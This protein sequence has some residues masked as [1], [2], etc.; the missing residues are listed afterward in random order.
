[1][2]GTDFARNVV[3]SVATKSLRSILNGA[4]SKFSPNEISQAIRKNESLWGTGEGDIRGYAGK[5][6]Y[7]HEYGTIFVDKI[8]ADYGSVTSLVIV[9][10]KEDQKSRWAMILNTP[11]GIEWLDRQVAEILQGLGLDSDPK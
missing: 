6:P 10:L 7:I 4:V 11:G 2:T 8:V 3:V 5:I 1:M 9:W